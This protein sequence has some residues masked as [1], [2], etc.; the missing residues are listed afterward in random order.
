MSSDNLETTIQNMRDSSICGHPQHYHSFQQVNFSFFSSQRTCAGCQG[1]LRAVIVFGSISSDASQQVLRCIAC[2]AMAHR[3]CALG[4]TRC[5]WKEVCP[6]N[7]KRL[8]ALTTSSSDEE[9]QPVMESAST[10]EEGEADDD[11]WTKP[12]DDMKPAALPEGPSHCASLEDVPSSPQHSSL[13][14][15]LSELPNLAKTSSTEL[16]STTKDPDKTPLHHTN[17]PF[18][19]VARALQENIL[20]HFQRTTRDPEH[21]TKYAQLIQK[22]EDDDDYVDAVFPNNKS[23]AAR[24]SETLQAAK[25]TVN[26]HP[27]GTAAVA[28]GIAG[29]VAGLV[30]AG[31]AGAYAGGKIGQVAGALGVLAEG[32]VTIGVIVASVATASITAKQIQEQIQER[33]VLT[34]GEA[35]T[36]RKV[37]LVRPDIQI[38]PVWEEIVAD[39]RASAPQKQHG[40]GG[41]LAKPVSESNHERYRRDSDIMKTD[42]EELAT[43]EKVLLLVSR[44]LSDKSSLP[45]HLYR[46]LIQ[47]FRD[48]CD[49][50]VRNAAHH[51]DDNNNTPTH[52]RRARRDDAHAVI[53]HV[54]GTL[55]ELRPE[56]AAS[57]EITELTAAAVE[58][59]VFG[60]L[61]ELVWEE[62]VAETAVRDAALVAKTRAF[63]RKLQLEQ[64]GTD[65]LDRNISQEALD[66]LRMFPQ[67]HTA[68][69]KLHYCVRFLELISDYV[70]SASSVCAESLLAMVCQH[71][72][73]YISS[74]EVQPKNF[75]AQVAF[76]EE[77]ARDEQL[78]RGRE[79]Y[80]LVTLQASLHFLDMSNDF[81]ADIFG[82]EDE[83]EEEAELISEK[84]VLE[85]EELISE[86]ELADG[87]LLV[88]V[89]E[90][91]ASSDLPTTT[92]P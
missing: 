21:A 16:D 72:C 8:K 6:V 39:A 82:S 5:V 43:K 62:I 60:Q 59:L 34:M 48:R 38:D 45:G 14:S 2:G 41:L 57:P 30:I 74:P 19:S 46:N 27:G 89:N 17:L 33:H 56:F 65:L 9:V 52:F 86:T 36:S 88:S 81:G 28:G 25:T 73:V 10:V 40:L 11:G 67:C 69:D 85:K 20:A 44:I 78:L 7:A 61:Y 91:R 31:P 76:L 53:K 90:E 35:G 22:D 50:R 68:V 83:E 49:E 18:A 3:S 37:L 23:I 64:G 42:E 87:A 24:A 15:K 75:H 26:K 77:F 63:R 80:S 1:R 54:T 92:P 47:T 4:G 70:S 32:S 29:G 51:H 55:L 79:G 13:D 58:G 12:S 66:A 71:L 84:E